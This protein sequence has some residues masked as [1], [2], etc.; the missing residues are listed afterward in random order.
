MN[1]LMNT[2]QPRLVSISLVQAL[3]SGDPQALED[4]TY[5]N[6]QKFL[7][8]HKYPYD[9][10]PTVSLATS[11]TDMAMSLL[12]ATV[13]YVQMRYGVESDGCVSLPDAVI[14]GSDF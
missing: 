13:D 3:L 5:D 8:E 11:A 7:I 9:K 2:R 6:R 4:L 1:D 10:V 12:K 14:P